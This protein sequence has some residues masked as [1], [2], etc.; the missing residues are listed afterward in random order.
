MSRAHK[1]IK[2][3]Y[4]P[5][6]ITAHSVH[7][8]TFL[9]FS[10]YLGVTDLINVKL[11]LAFLEFLAHNA[12]SYPV[13][14]NYVSS[15]RVQFK[16]FDLPVHV[17]YHQKIK[18]FLR[19]LSINLPYAP[20]HKGVFDIKTLKAIISLVSVTK[21]PII[22]KAIFL[23]AFY[24]FFRISNLL[25]TRPNSFDKTRHF[26]MGDIIWGA[27]G[28]HVVVKWI[29]SMQSRNQHTVVQIPAIHK[30]SIC[31]VAA[32]KSCMSKV[33]FHVNAPLF[34]IHSKSG[35][36]PITQSQARTT[37]AK[38]LSS[39]GMDPKV[40]GFH[41]FRRSGAT[42]AFNAHVPLQNIQQHGGWKSQA[43]WSYLSNTTTAQSVV[44][45]VFQSII[46]TST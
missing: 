33:P 18:L 35:Y 44:P 11:I 4:R 12:I 40:Y 20:K 17:L 32:L 23:L 9:A 45:Q 29:K 38:I 19:S 5:S 41:T 46:S 7:F 2:S 42:L 1:R 10:T 31:P 3:A 24:G 22:F 14:L 43:V 28:A 16:N 21:Y 36:I 34:A 37:L 26:T 8:R 25:P 13:I 39:L 27:P 6:T 30:S 15:L